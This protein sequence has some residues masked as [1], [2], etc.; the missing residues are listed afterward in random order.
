MKPVDDADWKVERP[1]KNLYATK[2]ITK[3]KNADNSE[4]LKQDWVVTDCEKQ[5]E[6][7]NN[8]TNMQRQ[9]TTE[10]ALY[11]KNGAAMFIVMYGQLHPKIITIAK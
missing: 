3:I 4:N 11:H 7:E 9:K 6:L 1:N 2:H 5:D 10:H 8:H